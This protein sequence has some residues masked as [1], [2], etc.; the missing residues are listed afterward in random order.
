[1]TTSSRSSEKIKVAVIT[2]HHPY[3]VVALQAFFRSLPEIDAYP[4]NL[5][6]FV[7]D[8]GGSRSEYEAV[9]FYNY[10]LPTP[11]N[12][13][14][15][16]GGNVRE[17]L[18]Q[19][20]ETDQGIFVL[21]HAILAYPDWPLWQQ[22]VG[23]IYPN[24]MDP[25]REVL[26]DQR[27]SIQNVASDHPITEGLRA[28][29]IVDETYPASEPGDG[30]EVLLTTNHPESMKTMAWTR[31]YKNAR[32]FCYQSGHDNVAFNNTSFQTVV[33]RGIQ[34]CARKI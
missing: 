1:M 32:V 27:V 8:E 18:E 17:V 34:W 16:L 4:Q 29:E 20:G 13:Q 26:Q 11:G 10:H 22:I 30:S 7:T 23:S 5:E 3:E 15:P 14:F 21:H 33:T 2:G 19:L 24:G 12:E 6:D 28:F 31:T 9:V 25:S